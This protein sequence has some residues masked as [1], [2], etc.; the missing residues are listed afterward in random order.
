MSAISVAHSEARDSGSSQVTNFK[1]SVV[2]RQIGVAHGGRSDDLLILLTSPW[3][4]SMYAY[5]VR[6]AS[7]RLYR[8][9][10]PQ[11]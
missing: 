4:E 1:K 3:P 9:H 10:R 6:Q 8:Q 2:R 11:N 5:P 7:Q